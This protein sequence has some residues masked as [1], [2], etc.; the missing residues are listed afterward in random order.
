MKSAAGLIA[1]PNR[2]EMTR[3]FSV[4]LLERD[5]IRTWPLPSATD[6]E[7]LKF[8]QQPIANTQLLRKILKGAIVAVVGLSGGGSPAILHLRCI[9]VGE[10]IGI[11]PQRVDHGNRIATTVFGWIEAQLGIHKVTAARWRV[12]FTNRS[13]RFTGVKASL[14]KCP[15][16]RR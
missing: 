4:R 15:L 13:V 7:Y 10:I 3:E 16:C 8:R 12:W 5:R 6:P 11:D 1:M 9:G 2:E 14:P